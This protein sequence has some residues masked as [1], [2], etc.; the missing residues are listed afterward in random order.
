[1]KKWIG[2]KSYDTDKA[3]KVCGCYSAADELEA[4]YLK[5]TGEFFLYRPNSEQIIPIKR[6]EAEEWTR[7]NGDS[8]AYNKFFGAI[9]GDDKRIIFSMGVSAQAI[10]QIKRDASD[11]GMQIGDYIAMKCLK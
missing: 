3:T 6:S 8:T 7:K 1:M 2:T 10:E 9:T 5:R 4:L 11:A